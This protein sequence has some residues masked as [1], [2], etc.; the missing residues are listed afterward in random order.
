MR[1]T[2]KQMMSQP[3]RTELPHILDVDLTHYIT[4][5]GESSSKDLLIPSTSLYSLNSIYVRCPLFYISLWPFFTIIIISSREEKKVLFLR[6]LNPFTYRYTCIILFSIPFRHQRGLY[7]D[8]LSFFPFLLYLCICHTFRHTKGWLKK[9][10]KVKT[11]QRNKE[12]VTKMKTH[13]FITPKYHIL[14]MILNYPNV[15]IWQYTEGVVLV[16]ILYINI[17]DNICTTLHYVNLVTYY[18]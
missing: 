4:A 8:W 13:H 17:L 11:F 5:F 1:Q 9:D 2:N 16:S 15:I 18:D 7:L 3:H 14:V 6:S 10:K 12:Y